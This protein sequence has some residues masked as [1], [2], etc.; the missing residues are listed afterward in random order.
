MKT[1][2]GTRVVVLLLVMVL[3][4]TAVGTASAQGSSPFILEC[5]ADGITVWAGPKAVFHVQLEQ[6]ARPLAT[7]QATGANQPVASGEGVSLWVLTSNE[8]QVHYDVN[9][10]ASHLI[11]PV[12]VCG[13]IPAVVHSPAPHPTKSVWPGYHHPWWPPYYTTP[14]AP[15]Q[16]AAGARIHVV[17]A[18]EN[19]FRIALK[20]GTTY[21]KLAAANGIVNPN[22]IYVGQQL[23]IP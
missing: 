8:L 6:I 17:A 3:A 9:P 12:D 22:R 19:L 14:V 10:A 13:A 5:I 7:A 1:G 20:Y 21:P 16:P 4:F 18:G 2:R 15:T 23:V 11:V